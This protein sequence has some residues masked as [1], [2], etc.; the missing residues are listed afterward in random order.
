MEFIDSLTVGQLIAGFAGLIIC[1]FSIVGWCAIVF[2]GFK[3]E[4]S[5]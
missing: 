4:V 1:A 5:K 2:N 3:D